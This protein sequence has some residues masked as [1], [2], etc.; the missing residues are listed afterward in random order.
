MYLYH[1][2]V[3]MHHIQ[4]RLRPQVQEGGNVVTDIKAAITDQL[5]RSSE[6]DQAA[7]DCRR[8]AGRLLAELRQG[9][10]EQEFDGEIHTLGLN[11]ET[12]RLLIEMGAGGRVMR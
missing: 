7:R 2:P 4:Q 8:T 1:Y 3:M 6:L 12:V 9:R 11:S 10:T 5:R